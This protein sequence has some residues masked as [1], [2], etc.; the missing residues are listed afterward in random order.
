VV[1]PP[2]REGLTVLIDGADGALELPVDRGG[3]TLR[4]DSKGAAGAP[5]GRT[6]PGSPLCCSARC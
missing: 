4:T 5:T 6:V 1:V 2:S 3:A